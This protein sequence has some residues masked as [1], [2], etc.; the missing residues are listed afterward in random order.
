MIFSTNRLIIREFKITDLE[1]VHS[2]ASLSYVVQYQAWGPNT[3]EE[4]Q[5]FLENA[6]LL[7][8]ETPRFSYEL[9]INLKSTNEQIGGC[10]IFIK[11]ENPKIAMIGYTLNPKFWKMGFGTE[12]TEGL[13]KFGFHELK[14]EIIQATC[15]VE[16]I[17]SKRVL[18]KNGFELLETIKGHKLQKG[19][20]R[21]SYLFSL[22]R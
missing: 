18:E 11:K 14:L 10:G 13:V 17:G 19:K 20:L 2:Y 16:N 22:K 3:L 4:T 15:D 8:N 7:I 1:S 6:I 21:S 12:V 5:F 9:C